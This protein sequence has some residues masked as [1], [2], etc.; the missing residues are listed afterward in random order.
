[1][2]YK[3]LSWALQQKG[4]KPETKNVLKCLADRHNPDYGTFPSISKIAEDAEMCE[5][6]VFN[7][8]S[9]LEKL[10]LIARSSRINKN[11]GQQTSNEYKL[12]RGVQNLHGDYVK[13]TA[14]GVKNLHTNLVSINHV[15]EPNK[16]TDLFD[17]YFQQW[18]E[19]YPRNVQKSSSKK[20]ALKAMSKIEPHELT[21]KLKEYVESV[22]NTPIQYIPHLSTWLNGERWNDTIEVNNVSNVDHAFRSMV[23]DLARVEG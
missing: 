16:S 15:S 3:A 13:P 17:A 8:L 7:H 23:T 18:W 21:E 12:F 5:K 11:S 20:A 14:V 9:K 19:M 6:S 1:M 10:G 22:K 2:S 4:L